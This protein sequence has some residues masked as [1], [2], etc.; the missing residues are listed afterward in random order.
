MNTT[1]MSNS[2][3]G[4]DR[5]S[6]ICLRDSATNR[7]ESALREVPRSFIASGIGSSSLG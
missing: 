2:P 7:R 6:P 3:K 5:N 4:R 1:A